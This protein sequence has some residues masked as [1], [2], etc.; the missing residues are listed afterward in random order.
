MM[1]ICASASGV[2]A[3]RA[4]RPWLLPS[5]KNG[6]IGYLSIDARVRNLSSAFDRARSCVISPFT[7]PVSKIVVL[8]LRVGG[9][10]AGRGEI[11]RGVGP[12]TLARWPSHTRTHTLM[13][14]GRWGS[15]LGWTKGCR[16]R[17]LYRSWGAVHMRRKREAD[18]SPNHSE[19]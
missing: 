13:E 7:V 9:S 17:L 18:L 4:R 14:S 10:K 8:G 2:R 11:R 19:S 1:R 6:T 16:I 5:S 3:Q 12:W 15:T